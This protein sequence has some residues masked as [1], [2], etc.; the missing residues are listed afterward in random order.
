MQG[1][2]L[3]AA[4]MALLAVLTIDLYCFCVLQRRPAARFVLVGGLHGVGGGAND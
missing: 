4:C 1:S 2:W 3:V